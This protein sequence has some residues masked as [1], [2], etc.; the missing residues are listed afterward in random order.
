MDTLTYELMN[1]ND[2]LD[3]TL[4]TFHEAKN[5]FIELNQKLNVAHSTLP[6]HSVM[7]F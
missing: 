3:A 5:Q 4:V 2:T 7:G 6:Q 1:A